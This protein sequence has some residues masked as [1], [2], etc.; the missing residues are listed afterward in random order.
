MA[1]RKSLA[2]DQAAGAIGGE[3]RLATPCVCS[4]CCTE[5]SPKEEPVRADR[6]HPYEPVPSAGV[7]AA[8]VYAE[9]PAAR[10][11]PNAKRHSSLSDLTFDRPGVFD[12]VVRTGSRNIGK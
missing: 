4:N 11:G 8:V 5:A 1:K 12:P 7:P 10:I 2:D 3:K 6:P 9:L